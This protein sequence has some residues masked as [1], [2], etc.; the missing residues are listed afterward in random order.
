[1]RLGTFALRD[2]WIS[3]RFWIPKLFD[4]DAETAQLRARLVDRG[5]GTDVTAESESLP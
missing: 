1:M 4:L 3:T 5:A 2:R